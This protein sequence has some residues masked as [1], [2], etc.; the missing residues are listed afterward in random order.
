M[1]LKRPS[2]LIR[3]RHLLPV[4][5]EVE[6][7]AA[8]YYRYM[9]YKKLFA[10]L[11]SI[12][13][14][15]LAS[16]AHAN[17]PSVTLFNI[18]PSYIDNAHSTLLSWATDSAS[19]SELYFPCIDG[20]SVQDGNG[21]SITCGTRHSAGSG[22]SGQASFTVINV[23]GAAQQIPV[24]IYPKDANGQDYDSGAKTAIAAV[25]TAAQPLTNF[26][27]S[28]TSISSGSAVT[29]SWT[30]QYIV[31]ANMSYSCND[32]ISVYAQGSNTKLMCNTPL[33]TTGGTTLEPSPTGSA[34]YTVVNSSNT[35]TARI[36][37]SVFPAIHTG[38]YD[39]THALSAQL[40]IA[41]KAAVLPPSIDYFRN[42]ATTSNTLFGIPFSLGWSIQHASGANLQFTCDS[43]LS[44]S[45]GSTTL[46]CN[47]PAFSAALSASSTVPIVITSRTGTPAAPSVTLLPQMAD[48]T[49]NGIV[50]TRLALSV[51]STSTAAA[52]A[53][54]PSIQTIVATSTATP[55]PNPLPLRGEGAAQNP[56]TTTPIKTNAPNTPIARLTIPLFRGSNGSQVK[57]LQ[58]FLARDPSVYPE[59]TVNGNF[60]PA[61]D[62]AVKRFQLKYSL[63]TANNPSYGFVGPAT[64]AVINAMGTR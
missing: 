53:P 32:N 36:T 45:V 28:S 27:L 31:G 62:A 50:A 25:G 20:I 59:G 42:L 61:T 57:A 55:H 10:V 24:T 30:G 49:Y 21:N 22:T 18:S 8:L 23:A 63:T 35:D 13:L 5:G 54:M 60:G 46:A 11:F 47:V 26:S 1:A 34:A 15:S 58:T 40:T 16:A 43:D 38:L 19:G 4:R 14:L 48:G 52:Q 37:F 29:L 6:T 39:M 64:R 17:T 12:G 56:A 2:P 41:P 3:L 44:Y 7:L 51:V 9:S 33:V